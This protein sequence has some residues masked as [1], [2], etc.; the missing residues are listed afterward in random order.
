MIE[1]I[2]TKKNDKSIEFCVYLSIRSRF[3]IIL[4]NHQQQILKFIKKDI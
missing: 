2:Q 3:R 1:F 4:V